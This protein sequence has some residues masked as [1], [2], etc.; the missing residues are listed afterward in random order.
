MCSGSQSGKYIAEKCGYRFEDKLIRDGDASSYCWDVVATV[1]LLHPE[2]FEDRFCHCYITEKGMHAGWLGVTQQAP[3]T[4][5]LNLPQVS[6][7][8]AY[9]QEMYGGWLDFR[10]MV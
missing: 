4:V 2:L 6:D 10:V 5:L 3:D 9:R 1:Y 8:V 7:P